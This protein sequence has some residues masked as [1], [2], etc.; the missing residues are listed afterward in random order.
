MERDPFVL[1]LVDGDGMIFDEQF[2]KKGEQGGKEAAGLLWGS[3][4]DYIRRENPELPSDIRIVTRIYANLKG[5]SEACYKAGLVERASLI[6]DFARGFTGS[7]QL[8][9]YIDVGSGKDRADD[10]LTEIFKLHLYDCH[11]RHIIFGCSHDN[12]YAR[13]LEDLLA[14]KPT[15][16]RVT[17]LE[18]VPFEKELAVLKKTYETTKFNTLFRTMKINLYHPPQ[19]PPQ[20]QYPPPPTATRTLSIPKTS[21]SPMATSWASTTAMSVPAHVASPP[22]N[23]KP[24]PSSVTISRN[25]YGQRVDPQILYD[26][27]EVNRVKKIHMCNVHYLRRD[28]PYGDE[29]SHDHKY[30]PSNNELTTLKYVARMTPC[31]FGTDCDDTKCIYGHRCPLSQPGSTECYFKENCRFDLEMHGIDTNVVKTVK[32]GSY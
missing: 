7:K 27:N 2:L 17:L 23:P 32:V 18:G 3:V 12:G 14:D 4:R 21:L 30:K 16:K 10:K 15:I 26:K 20:I 29:C 24:A 1:V 8:F 9:D 13:L 31:K 25:K 6:E 19:P 22:P 5:L 28:C 11:C